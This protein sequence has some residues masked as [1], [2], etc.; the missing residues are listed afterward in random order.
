MNMGV[1]LDTRIQGPWTRMA[2][3]CEH[4]P[5]TLVVC[6]ELKGYCEDLKI[7]HGPDLLPS[8]LYK[9]GRYLEVYCVVYLSYVILTR[10]NC[11]VL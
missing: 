10:M 2:C 4:G 9:N 11:Y 1:I 6:T 3:E 7:N 5:S 8:A